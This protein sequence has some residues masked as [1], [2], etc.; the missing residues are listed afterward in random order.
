MLRKRAERDQ[1]NANTMC[2]ALLY[3]PTPESLGKANMAATQEVL[4]GDL[5][6]LFLK[7]ALSQEL[8]GA[9]LLG[10]LPVLLPL[11]P[12]LQMPVVPFL[13]NEKC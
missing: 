3:A 11:F 6:W 1:H 2:L 7:S 12:G 10:S 13:W 4:D 8:E 5:G 9:S